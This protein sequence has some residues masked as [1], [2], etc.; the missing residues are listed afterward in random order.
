MP[1]PRPRRPSLTRRAWALLGASLDVAAMTTSATSAHAAST[2]LVQDTFQRANVG[3]GWGTATDGNSWSI[4]SGSGTTDVSAD[5]GQIG[6]TSSSMFLVLGA[7][8]TQADSNSLVRFS[9]TSGVLA[10]IVARYAGSGGYYLLRQTGSQLQLIKNVSG[11]TS[12][13]ATYAF[14]PSA[15]SFCWMRLLVQGT[16]LEARVWQDGTTEPS[17]WQISVTDSSITAAGYAGLYGYNGTTTPRDYDHFSV[18]P[19]GSGPTAALTLKPTSTPVGQAITA[20]ASA[21]TA[22]GNPISSYS[23]NFGDGTSAVTVNAPADTTTHTYTKGGVFTVTVTVTD[24]AGN[25]S[26]AT[27]T[28]RGG[29]RVAPRWVAPSSGNPPLQVKADASGSSDATGVSITSYSFN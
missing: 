3:S 25:S 15:N 29:R 7:K 17:A 23:F 4:S 10:G 9:V 24:S 6:Q 18:A 14:T 12:T 13:L 2:Y 26:Q 16:S 22:G 28:E 19:V 5:E 21:S 20:D 8:L 11:A 27:A 1:A